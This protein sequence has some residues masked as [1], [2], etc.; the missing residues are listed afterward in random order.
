MFE[1]HI[2][3]NM[4]FNLENPVSF[5]GSNLYKNECVSRNPKEYAG[6]WNQNEL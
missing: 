5:S 6:T 1:T 3:Q 2:D 4:G